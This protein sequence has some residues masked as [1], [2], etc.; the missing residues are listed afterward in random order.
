VSSY[1]GGAEPETG[2]NG[3]TVVVNPSAFKLPAKLSA[4]L[5]TRSVICVFLV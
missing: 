1:A 3:S 5:E 2:A 4:E